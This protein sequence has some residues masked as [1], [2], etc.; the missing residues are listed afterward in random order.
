MSLAHGICVSN[1]RM[2]GWWRNG[3]ESWKKVFCEND[4]KRVF[5]FFS[6][7]TQRSRTIAYPAKSKCPQVSNS[8]AHG[9]MG[10]R[11][12]LGGALMSGYSCGVDVE[13]GSEF[14]DCAPEQQRRGETSRGICE[15]W[16]MV[17]ILL[18]IRA[19]ETGRGLAKNASAAK[20]S[21]RRH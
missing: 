3:R 21:W 19:D 1:G 18:V 12:C 9:S 20:S 8:V 6:S 10:R 2:S 16:E 7:Y 14:G 5:S 4:E 15:S 13:V 17:N 11:R